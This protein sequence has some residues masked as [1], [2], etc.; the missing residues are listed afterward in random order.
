MGVDRESSITCVAVAGG[1]DGRRGVGRGRDDCCRAVGGE[2][3]GVR[4]KKRRKRECLK[5]LHA[6]V[7]SRAA[8]HD[9]GTCLRETLAV[10]TLST[11]SSLAK[12]SLSFLP[13]PTATLNRHTT[14]HVCTHW[15]RLIQHNSAN[16]IVNVRKFAYLIC[17]LPPLFLQILPFFDDPRS[18]IFRPAPFAAQEKSRPYNLLASLHA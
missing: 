8:V 10:Q 11:A 18:R 12:S 1:G 7:A 9:C 2:V 3:G 16:S 13:S 6:A 17:S 5:V 15:S 14:T 4:N